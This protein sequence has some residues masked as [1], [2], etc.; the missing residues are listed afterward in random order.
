MV[1]RL[2]EFEELVEYPSRKGCTEFILRCAG[3]VRAREIDRGFTSIQVDETG[4]G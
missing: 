2:I 3:E 4:Q 1:P